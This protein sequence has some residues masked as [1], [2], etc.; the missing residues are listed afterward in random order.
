MSPTAYLVAK[1]IHVGCVVV[2][3]A[4]FGVRGLLMLAD[5]P[6]L[7][8]RLVRVA[9]HIVDTLLLASAL[10]LAWLLGQYPFVHAWLTA[11][12]LGLLAYIGFGTVALRRGR[13][14]SLR[15]AALVAATLAAAYVV[16]VALTRDPR[17]PLVW[18]GA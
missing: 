9:P 14:K 17:G 15:S 12:V 18:L 13:T 6:R 8:A 1:S 16:A 7:S 3:L 5:S 4:G 2:S 10:W 11:K